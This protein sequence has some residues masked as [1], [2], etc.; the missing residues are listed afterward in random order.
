MKKAT[1]CP[2]RQKSGTMNTKS[3]KRLSAWATL[4]NLKKTSIA[5]CTTLLTHK[6]D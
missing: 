2:K 3:A 5:L 1:Q 4:E 6:N